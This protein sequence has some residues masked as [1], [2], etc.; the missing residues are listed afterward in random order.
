MEK[1]I[2]LSAEERDNLA[3][4]LDGE[5]DDDSAEQIERKLAASQTAR[6]DVELLSRSYDLLDLLPRPQTNEQ[7]TDRT[8]S[9]ARLEAARPALHEQAW[10]PWVRRAAILVAWVAGLAGAAALGYRV[11]H[12]WIPNDAELLLHD[13]PVIENLDAYREVESIEFL[14]ELQKSKTFN[15]PS[16][17]SDN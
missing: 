5:L 14:R 12:D 1:L 10:F 17:S 3:A 8:L 6:H 16:E 9:M 2:R 11:T 15:A 4:Y 7:F 13:L